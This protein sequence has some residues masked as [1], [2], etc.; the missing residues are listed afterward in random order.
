MLY[1]EVREITSNLEFCFLVKT[2]PQSSI[3]AAAAAATFSQVGSDAQS[4]SAK[5][6]MLYQQNAMAA[7]KYTGGEAIS[8]ETAKQIAYQQEVCADTISYS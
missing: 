1:I 5:A 3:A 6:Q 8:K 7:K 2:E 4:V